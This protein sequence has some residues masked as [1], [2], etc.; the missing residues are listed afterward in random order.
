MH[1][2]N[3]LTLL[4]LSNFTFA[5]KLDK[6]YAHQPIIS[7]I[8]TADPSAHVF[9]GKIYIYPSHDIATDKPNTNG[10]H[11]DMRDYHVFSMDSIGGKVIDHGVAL[12]LKDVP[13]ADRQLWAPD[14]AAKNGKYYLYFPAKDKNG[15]FRMGVAVSKSPVGLFKAQPNFIKDSF[16]IDPSVFQDDDG[17]SYMYFGGIWGGQLQQWATGTFDK[18]ETR[19]EVRAANEVALTGKIAKLKSNM[20]EFSEKPKDVVL[21]DSFGKPLLTG[22]QDR[23]FFEGAWVF[24]H[25]NKYYFTYSTGSTHKIVYAIGDNPYGPF[26]YKGVVLNPVQ[27]WTTHHSIINI[28]GNFYLFYH[29]TELSGKSHL[30]NVKI[31]PLHISES[32]VIQTVNPFI[33]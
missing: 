3:I 20:L 32:G 9:N 21:L 5:Q 12:D 13:W 31:A 8:Y 6:K 18:N 15:I 19:K 10:D 11:F 7:H 2:L 33:K 14:A 26:T 29:D 30:R 25:Q 24:K 28:K 22:D 23:R 1:R 17:E 4:F 16:S 27:G